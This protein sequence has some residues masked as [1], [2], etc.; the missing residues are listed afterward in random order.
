[1]DKKTLKKQKH[2]TMETFLRYY[3]NVE[4]E[5]IIESLSGLSHKELK[6]VCK[7]IYGIDL[8]SV[9]FE[10]VTKLDLNS[11]NILLVHDNYN[12]PAPY[13]NPSKKREQTIIN[14]QVRRVMPDDSLDLEEIIDIIE[15]NWT[16]PDVD[17]S[18]IGSFTL[19]K[20]KGR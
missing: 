17:I 10:I 4:D 19:T 8:L 14:E 20:K 12:N 16:I 3:C 5:A 11:G 9:P 6:A 2:I 18:T 1:M 7:H 13:I 15:E